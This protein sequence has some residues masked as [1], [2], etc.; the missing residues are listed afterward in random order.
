MNPNFTYEE[1]EQIK[2]YIKGLLVDENIGE[3]CVTF[4]KGDGTERVLKCTL[5]E[6][7]IPENKRPKEKKDTTSS[8]EA[9]RVFDLE[10]QDWRSFRWDS[11]KTFSFT[12][13]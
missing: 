10:K 12:L 7:R 6:S 3:V 1:V 9:I 2:T 13:G 5:V 8:T 11:V 4:T